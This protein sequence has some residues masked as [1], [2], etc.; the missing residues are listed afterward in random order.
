MGDSQR[1]PVTRRS[2]L[3]RLRD[4]RDDEAWNDFVSVYVPVILAYAKRKGLGA[5]QAADVTQEVLAKVSSVVHTFEYDAD[6]GSFRSWLRTVCKCQLIDFLRRESRHPTPRGDT[7]AMEFLHNLPDDD[8]AE[9]NAWDRDYRRYM[10]DW[11]IEKVRPTVTEVTWKA[12]WMS[13]MEHRST[14]DIAR[15]LS[16]SEGAV[17]TARSRVQAKLRSAVEGFRDE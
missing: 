6:K 17:Y 2:L 1:N 3:V 5:E 16:M 13:A 12:F 7:E 10:L 15:H 4:T 14:K 8:F 9:Q 11:A